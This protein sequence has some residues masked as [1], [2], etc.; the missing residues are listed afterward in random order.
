M[1]SILFYNRTKRARGN[2]FRPFDNLMN[3]ELLFWSGTHGG[4]TAWARMAERHALTSA[5]V[6]VRADGSTAHVALFD[7]VTGVLERTVTWQGYSDSSAWAREQA[8]AIHGL[9]ASYGHTKR[10]ELLAAAKRAA[11]WFIAHLPVDQVPYWDFRHPDIP[12]TERDA[13]AGAIAASVSMI[14]L[15][16][17]QVPRARSTE[18]PR[19]A[20]SS[21][22]RRTMSR[23]QRRPKRFFCTP[24][25]SIR[26]VPRSTAGSCMRTTIS[27]R[28]CCGGRGCF[29][30]NDVS[31]R[32]LLLT[33]ASERT[34]L[35]SY[36]ES[37]RAQQKLRK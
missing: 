24:P 8:W 19:I 16:T 33:L 1:P 18:P 21:L 14:S 36:D 32:A 20:S 9:T 35:E 23:L 3:L 4:D 13:S 6:H 5:R 12:N 15:G 29:W 25:A 27:S 7:P 11:D 2:F 31:R 34:T 28:R 30:N 37:R 26:R 17:H 22:S 10:P